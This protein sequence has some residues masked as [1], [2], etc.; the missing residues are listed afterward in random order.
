MSKPLLAGSVET[1]FERWPRTVQLFIQ[2]QMACPGCD[3]AEFESLEGALQ[4]YQLESEL[5][6]DDLKQIIS[7]GEGETC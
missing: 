1:L 5:F 2:Y 4:V 3:L 6:L 7:N